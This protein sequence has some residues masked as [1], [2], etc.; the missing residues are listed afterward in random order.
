VAGPPG[1]PVADELAQAGIVY[2]PLSLVGAVPAPGADLRALRDIRALLARGAHDLVHTHGQKAGI[3]GRV[4]AQ[5]A[6][7][8]AIYTPHF[9]VYRSQS[10]RGR[11]SARVRGRVG[12][13]VERGLSRRSAG[14]IAVCREERDAAVSDHIAPPERVTV[15]LNG[16]EPRQGIDPDPVLAAFRAPGPL[17]GIVASLREQKGLPTLLEALE[18]LVRAGTP[19]RF[20]IVGN[21]PL[22]AEVRERVSRGPLAATTLALSFEGRVEPYLNALDAF[23]LPSY[24]EGLPIAIL[25]AMALGLP[26][27]ATDVGGVVEAVDDERTGL[28]VA[29]RD[30]PGLAAAM[31]RL[32]ADPVLRARLGA[33]G[34][35]VAAQRFGV[36]RMVLETEAVYERAVNDRG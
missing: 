33:S 22:E 13:A 21:G 5:R 3:L 29:A 18:L 19:V 30:A 7:V 17:L 32:A 4:A 1:A 26:V 14:L 34:R 6:G 10:Q 2:H 15:V 23:V 12:L 16:V 27:V 31:A 11:L 36:A 28:V 8:P 9:F 35:E 20:A 25:E 24:W